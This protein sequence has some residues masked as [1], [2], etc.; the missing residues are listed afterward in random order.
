MNTADCVRIFES[1]RDP[2]DQ[3]S[4]HH[5][6]KVQKAQRKGR[7]PG[8]PWISSVCRTRKKWH[9]HQHSPEPHQTAQVPSWRCKTLLWGEKNY[10]P[11]KWKNNI[12]DPSH[13]SSSCVTS[14]KSLHIW[15]AVLL[16][17]NW[18][19]KIIQNEVPSSLNILQYFCPTFLS[20]LP[21]TQ[22]NCLLPPLHCR[23]AQYGSINSGLLHLFTS[24]LVSL[25]YTGSCL[26]GRALLYILCSPS[27]SPSGNYVCNQWLLKRPVKY[28][29]YSNIRYY[30]Y[31][32]HPK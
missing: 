5:W 24:G 3:N 25:F 16:S 20:V 7:S 8:W 21:S 10:C 31:L 18:V 2:E 29:L 14:G 22:Q 4:S 26:K 19:C 30:F 23:D 6:K 12:P 11:E 28:N 32:F 27:T 15:D 9:P 1:W 17:L 13:C